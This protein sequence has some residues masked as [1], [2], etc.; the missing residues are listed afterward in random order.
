MVHSDTKTTGEANSENNKII[1]LSMALRIR[2]S[3]MQKYSFQN[4]DKSPSK[5]TD[6]RTSKARWS[7]EDEGSRSNCISLHHTVKPEIRNSF[8]NYS[9]N[10]KE[11]PVLH[12]S[13]EDTS[14][15][16][17]GQKE[18]HKFTTTISIPGRKME[19][20]EKADN[21]RTTFQ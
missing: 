12:R 1:R 7:I 15:N 4:H 6:T 5:S 13:F 18:V 11:T 21:S 16:A 20:C 3:W 8:S 17:F 9:Y 14:F 10:P 19:A 2:L